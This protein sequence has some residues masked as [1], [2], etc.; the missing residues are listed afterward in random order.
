ML[1]AERPEVAVAVDGAGS[2]HAAGKSTAAASAV[3]VDMGMVAAL[4]SRLEAGQPP[5]PW[6]VGQGRPVEQ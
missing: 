6:A 2:L 1:M 4:G 3:D 5:G